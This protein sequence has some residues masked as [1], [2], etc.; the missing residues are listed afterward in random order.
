M[1][2]DDPINL[3]YEQHSNRLLRSMLRSKIPGIVSR[4]CQVVAGNRLLAEWTAQ[5][6]PNVTIIPTSVD[7]R[8]YAADV[9][10]RRAGEKPVIGWIGTPM[11]ARYLRLL[12]RPLRA[13]RTRHDFVLK[14][15]GAPNF[16]MEGIEVQAVPWSEATEVDELRTCD[17]G[18]MPIPDD[19]WAR[20]KSALKLIQYL[21]AG[22]AAV[23]S[24]V[25]ANCDVLQESRNGLFAVTEED[26]TEKLAALIER[27]A[28]REHLARA[29]RHTVEERFSLQGNAPRFTVILRQAAAT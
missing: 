2:Y 29:G 17:I 26:W 13:L 24:P 4:S 21:A 6:N 10:R 28:Y 16:T 9:P 1:D 7:L 8:K 19:P 12:E 20:G 11:T 14:V 5:F 22:V 23:A 3:N 25:G 27:P 18:I 15:I